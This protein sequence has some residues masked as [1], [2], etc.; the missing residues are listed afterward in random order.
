MLFR[1]ENIFFDHAAPSEFLLLILKPFVAEKEKKFN[2]R[3]KVVGERLEG[4]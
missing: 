4:F 1:S 3:A 2:E